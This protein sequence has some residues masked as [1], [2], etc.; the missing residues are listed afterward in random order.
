MHQRPPPG[1]EKEDE[2]DVEDDEDDDNDD[3][4]VHLLMRARDEGVSDSILVS[5][6]IK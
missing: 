4:A 6:H 2:T 5:L 1:C 3:Y